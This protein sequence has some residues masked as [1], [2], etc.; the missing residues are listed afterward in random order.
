MSKIKKGLRDPRGASE[1]VAAR[2]LWWTWRRNRVT[3]IYDR[4]WDVAII[5]D[6]C[7]FDLF[8][9]ANWSVPQSIESIYSVA[10]MTGDWMERTF[11]DNAEDTIYVTAAPFSDQKL[12]T[13]QFSELDEVW[14]YG[15]DDE[16]GTVPPEW[17]TDRAILHRRKNGNSRLVV[18]YMQPHFPAIE[19]P[20]LGSKIQMSQTEHWNSIWERLYYGDVSQEKVWKAYQSNLKIV[21]EE[22]ETLLRNIGAEEVILTSDHGNAMGEAGR[23]GHPSD[24]VVPEVRRVPWAKIGSTEDQRTRIPD[25][26]KRS[27]E[28]EYPSEADSVEEKLSALGYV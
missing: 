22:V 11:S 13:T 21:L 19:Y 3:N 2:L 16:L 28:R 1:Y 27:P 20:E 23:Y 14:R 15:F 25:D 9:S 26:H 4:D 8:K 7:R 5:L 24:A 18:H 10:S 17:V 12:S 6:A